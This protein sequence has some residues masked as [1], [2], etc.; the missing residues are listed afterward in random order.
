MRVLIGQGDQ[1]RVFNQFEL[2]NL[3]SSKRDPTHLRYIKYLEA[4]AFLPLN[5][6]QPYWNH[7]S[8]NV[9]ADNTLPIAA[10]RG[11]FNVFPIS[12]VSEELDR[13]PPG[14]HLG[15]RGGRGEKSHAHL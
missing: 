6:D 4:E 11:H 7:I 3:N 2:L 12:L 14:T 8:N 1:R 5:G 10:H 15:K 13:T 9:L